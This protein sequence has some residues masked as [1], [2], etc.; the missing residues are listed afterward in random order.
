MS[1]T[2]ARR[3]RMGHGV[4]LSCTSRQAV[5]CQRPEGRRPAALVAHRARSEHIGRTQ[6]VRSRGSPPLAAV[7]GA[8]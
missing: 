7:C 6:G 5:A 8:A 3:R 1:T 2:S 4:T